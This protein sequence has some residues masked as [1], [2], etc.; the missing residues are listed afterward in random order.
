M[1]E[2]WCKHFWSER[3]DCYSAGT[4]KHGMNSRAIQVM[5]DAGID[6]SG[7]YSKTIDELKEIRFDWIITVCDSAKESCPIYPGVKTI[8]IGFQDPP[9]LTLGMK[10]EMEILEVYS[11][12]RDEI[13]QVIRNL[14]NWIKD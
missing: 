14:P 1:A 4:E 3:Y 8:H 13:Q 12:V 5:K 9:R 7:H 6:L 10:D 2:G 11:R